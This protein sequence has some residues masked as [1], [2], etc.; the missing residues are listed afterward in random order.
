MH[1][2]FYN[3]NTMS[4]MHKK[5]LLIVFLFFMIIIF[6]TA[7]YIFI[8]D[9]S[10]LDGLYMTVI[11]LGTVGFKEVKELDDNGKIFTII[12]I[13]TGFGLFSYTLT[14]GAKIIV[15]GEIKE[16]FKRRKMSKEIKSL[17]DHYV[18]CGYG[19]MGSIIARELKAYKIPLVVVEKNIENIS[20][21]DNLLYIV[22]D[23][24]Q[25][26][27]LKKAGIERA[28]GL[29]TVLPSDAENLY[30]VL[31]ARELNEKL[32][33][34]A[35][36]VDKE[37]ERKLRRAGAD[38]V[39]SPYFIG[40]L[41]IAHTV[42][43]PNVVD[44]LE[45]ATRAEHLEIQIEEIEVSPKSTL[46]GKTIAE[47]GLG[48]DLGVIVIAIKRIDGRMKFNPTSQTLIKEGDILIVLGN[49]DNLINLEKIAK[50]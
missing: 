29:V 13:L 45:F 16:V 6:G 44:F 4:F 39:G 23:A 22:G 11:T 5:L 48:R 36:A 27:T 19:R 3:R 47:S 1:K 25:D 8:E 21:E 34:V 46:I 14:V 20:E 17:S 32:F 42:L 12:L 37:A 26:D 50:G 43:R 28:K 9:M 35:R 10:L 41:R 18:I 24:I 30:V 40:G 33:I 31:S 7:G 2:F 15:E 49:N 38:R